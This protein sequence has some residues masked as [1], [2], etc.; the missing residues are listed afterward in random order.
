MLDRLN[1]AVSG[2]YVNPPFEL[3]PEK[4]NQR[5]RARLTRLEF[6]VLGLSAGMLLVF[7]YLDISADIGAFPDYRTFIKTADGIYGSETGGYF[8]AHWF[9]PVFEVL[10]ILPLHLGYIVWGFM[11]IL[12][13]WYA[14][15]VFG[16][17]GALALVSYQ[18]LYVLFYGN[19]A[20]VIAGALAFMWWA[21]HSK[22]WELAGLGWVI[23]ATKFQLG[24]P[25]GLTLLL[26]ADISWFARL[27]VLAIPLLVT[28][29]SLIVYPNW[30]LTLYET[31]LAVPPD[32]RGSIS[33]WQWFGALTLILWIPPLVLRLS[34]GRRLPA[35]TAVLALAIPY[36]QQ[37]DLLALYV[38][39]I[40]LLPLLGNIG[41]LFTA[42]Q[43]LGL[44]P[45][46]IIPL[47]LY[48]WAVAGV[49]IRLL[50][51]RQIAESHTQ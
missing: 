37:T 15:R 30:P 10:N 13:V 51:D 29:V 19:I 21:L 18:M 11:N 27:R 26:I 12:G 9:I 35:I 49:T 31:T 17:N 2:R 46:V 40:G 8:Y 20:G 28:L 6:F 41:Y 24:V 1:R 32:I 33:L 4:I 25:L 38:L 23:A 43:W 48:I 14:A 36:F 5:L 50:S 22:R 42:F 7:A 45:L 34:P 16:G 39:P 44:K 47:M 3:A